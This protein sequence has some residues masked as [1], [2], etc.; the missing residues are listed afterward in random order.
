MTSLTFH[1]P[2]AAP[3]S[4]TLLE[5]ESNPTPTTFSI[6]VAITPSDWARLLTEGLF[7]LW[8][9]D[10]NIP[11]FETENDIFLTLRLTPALARTLPPA[12]NTPADFVALPHSDSVLLFNTQSWFLLAATQAVT[13]PPELQSPEALLNVGAA[14]EWHRLL[15]GTPTLVTP[16]DEVIRAFFHQQEWLYEELNPTLW[17]LTIAGDDDTWVVLVQLNV[18]DELCSVYSVF[19]DEVEDEA[20]RPAVA[21]Y[22]SE[23]NYDLALGNWEMDLSDG[24]IRFRTSLDYEGGDLTPALFARLILMNIHAAEVQFEEIRRHL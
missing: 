4:A 16:P 13:L 9:D 24:E 22:L 6:R 10:A 15:N 23:V 20:K 5:I 18:E 12:F 17:R 7:H 3:L 2:T 14:T 21:A 11:L 8:F 19:P 1:T